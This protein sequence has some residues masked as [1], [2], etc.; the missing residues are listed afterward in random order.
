MLPEDWF[1]AT[2]RS[3]EAVR[4][5]DASVPSMARLWNYLVGGRDN[6]EADRTATNRLRAAA[7]LLPQLAQAGLAFSGRVVGYLAGEAGL[8]QFIDVSLGM[9]TSRVTHEAAQAAAPGSSVVY[10][11]SDPVALTHARALLRSSGEGAVGYVRADVRDSAAILAGASQTLDLGR[12]VAVLMIDVL[13]FIE[14]AGA[15]IAGLMAAL[16]AGSCVAVMQ[17]VR[18]ERLAAGARL[19]GKIVHVPIFPR[20]GD[21]VARW[22]DGLELVEPGIVEVPQWRPARGDHDHP[23]GIPLLGAVARKP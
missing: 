3:I 1:R 6:F 2:S 9:W 21:E 23:L 18:D 22:L 14:D 16:P 20:D 5:V 8:R 15:V 10:A 13:N 4:M 12:P 19:W 17:V 7:P 11:T